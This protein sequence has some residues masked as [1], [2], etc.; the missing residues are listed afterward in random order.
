MRSV[1]EKIKMLRVHHIL[2]SFL[3]DIF[4]SL[5]KFIG[6]HPILFLIVPLIASCL[7]STGMFQVTYIRWACLLN[8]FFCFVKP[9]IF[10]V[11]P[12]ICSLQ[13][14]EW[15]AKREP[16][17][18]NT[19]QQTSGERISTKKNLFRNSGTFFF[20]KRFIYWILKSFKVV[21]NASTFDFRPI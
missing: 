21:V 9:Q 18:R 6:R 5:G 4:R 12:I 8:G 11:T 1:G 16:W 14:M 13:Q 10:L 19:F 7:L 2:D 17:R 3:K 20:V 15:A